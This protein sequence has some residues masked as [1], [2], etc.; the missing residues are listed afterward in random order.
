MKIGIVTTYDEINYGAFLQAYSLQKF[1]E[2]EGYDVEMI[3]YKSRRYHWAELRATYPIRSPL[4]SL[5]I[6]RKS[7]R[8]K[9][10]Q[11]NL[12]T[13]ARIKDKN[14]KIDEKYKF[15]IFGSDEIWNVKNCL[16]GI[17]EKYFFGVGMEAAKKIAYAASFGS[18]SVS[19]DLPADVIKSLRG[20]EAIGVRDANSKDVL[21]S[22]NIEKVSIVIDPTFLIEQPVYETKIRSPYLLY[23]CVGAST[24]YDNEIRE[25]ADANGIVYKP[26]I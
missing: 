19:D 18:T 20:S 13:S 24:E 2:E 15:I 22:N 23:Y 6:F 17:V 7:L 16:G 14:T 8:F 4:Y 10:D 25:F 26:T 1:L 21:R 12:K 11:K 5:G 3:N 9:K